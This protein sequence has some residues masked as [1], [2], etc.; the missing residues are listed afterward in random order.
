MKTQTLILL[1]VA[2][3]ASIAITVGVYVE[4]KQSVSHQTIQASQGA[5]MKSD[6][7][8]VVVEEARA[9]LQAAM[10]ESSL[11]AFKAEMSRLSDAE[12]NRV[13]ASASDEIK[14]RLAADPTGAHRSDT[15]TKKIAL[16]L[17]REAAARLLLIDRKLDSIK[18]TVL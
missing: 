10:P 5:M 9:P 18:G 6:K 1:I 16:E 12:L 7:K 3:M 13:V 14:K 2:S 15:D 8:S 11:A 4:S 17:D